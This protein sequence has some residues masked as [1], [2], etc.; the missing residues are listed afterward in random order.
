MPDGDRRRGTGGVP[1]GEQAATMQRRFQSGPRADWSMP[2]ALQSREWGN[3]AARAVDGRAIRLPEPVTPSTPAAIEPRIDTISRRRPPQARPQPP[4]LRQSSRRPLP[5]VV[6]NP[7]TEQAAF[8]RPPSG[9]DEAISQRATATAAAPPQPPMTLPGIIRW[10]RQDQQRQVSARRVERRELALQRDIPANIP[11]RDDEGNLVGFTTGRPELDR[12]LIRSAGPLDDEGSELASPDTPLDTLDRA[13]TRVTRQAVS[14]MS[15]TVEDARQWYSRFRADH[16]DD[17][18]LG[19]LLGIA[20]GLITIGRD[21]AGIFDLIEL[22]PTLRDVGLE[23]GRAYVAF[24][25]TGNDQQLVEVGALVNDVIIPLLS[26]LTL[27]LATGGLVGGAQLVIERWTNT[28]E[29]IGAFRNH[30]AQQADVLRSIT[31]LAGRHSATHTGSLG[32]SQ[33]GAIARANLRQARSSLARY[34]RL[35]R[36]RGR[37]A[38]R[39]LAPAS[40]RLAAFAR[41]FGEEVGE[42]LEDER[43]MVAIQGRLPRVRRRPDAHSPS[44]ELNLQRR[45]EAQSQEIDPLARGLSE[46]SSA[47]ANRG[48]A[49]VGASESPNARRPVHRENVPTGEW[50]E[51]DRNRRETLQELPYLRVAAI[52]ATREQLQTASGVLDRTFGPQPS[53]F[54]GPAPP[55]GHL[56]RPAYIATRIQARMREHFLAQYQQVP[57][58]GRSMERYLRAVLTEART[59]FARGENQTHI[60]VAGCLAAVCK[61]PS[62]EG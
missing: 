1:R 37:Q 49:Y 33:L 32:D 54:E 30:S 6:A 12:P 56:G 27:D 22:V 60:Y 21:A 11:V 26:Q 55:L 4:P 19:P 16:G 23:L 2:P 14:D 3:D 39:V 46:E 36:V 51:F 45:R 53:L 25:E 9:A 59:R 48:L 57:T 42:L 52:I 35:V 47:V 40:E 8:E 50:S 44:E 38:G 28:W 17:P 20:E 5:P 24:V 13:A 31:E 34:R 58:R 10:S 18:E 62:C 15:R 61:P 29:T 7:E 41:E 43:G